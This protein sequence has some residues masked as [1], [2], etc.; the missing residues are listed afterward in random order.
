V[1]YI[2]H[3]STPCYGIGESE[4]GKYLV[5]MKSCATI[6]EVTRAVGC[7]KQ[8]VCAV[9]PAGQVFWIEKYD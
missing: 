5:W 8:A 6:E 1:K 3:I 9:Q 7:G 4:P 2:P